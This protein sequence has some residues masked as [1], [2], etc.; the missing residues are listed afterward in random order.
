MS[1]S[2]ARC[3]LV[4]KALQEF[5]GTAVVVVTSQGLVRADDGE[6]RSAS[7]DCEGDSNKHEDFFHGLS[8]QEAV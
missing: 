1:A 7:G 8:S 4:T 2:G 6:G 5:S 3:P